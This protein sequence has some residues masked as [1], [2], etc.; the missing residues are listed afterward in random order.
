MALPSQ[1]PLPSQAGRCIQAYFGACKRIK[2]K[3][4]HVKMSQ[5]PSFLLGKSAKTHSKK[6]SKNM[7]ISRINQTC[8]AV[9][10]PLTDGGP[11]ARPP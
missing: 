3:N 4:L 6:P 1:G 11:G 9:P 10:F 7:Q 5:K 8:Q 2:A